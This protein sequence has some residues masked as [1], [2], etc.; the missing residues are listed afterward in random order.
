MND[1]PQVR[2]KDQLRAGVYARL[3]ETYDAAESVPTQ[4]TNATR[5][6]E[7]RG[8]RVAATF[9]DDGYSAFKE[10][11]RDDFVRLIDAI[12]HGEIDVVIVRDVDRLTRNLTDWNRFEKACVG[13]GVLLSAYTGG[14]LDLSTPE[15]AYYGGMETLRAKRESAVRSARVREAKDR[16][17]RKG[18]RSGGGPRWFGYT[19][20]YANPDEPDKRKRIVLRDEI[21]QV[22]AEA[23]R[24]AAERLLRGETTGSIIREW[25]RRGITPSGGQEW[26]VTSLTRTITSPRLAGLRQ[27]QGK[28][29][30]AEWP[31]IFDTDTHERLVKLFGDPS[32]RAH[33]VGRKLHLLSGIAACGKCG[34]PLYPR[35]E[36][37]Y[38]SP[39]YRCVKQPGGGGCGGISVNAELLEEY[40]T[41]AVLDALESPRVQ[42]AVRAGEDS[43]APRRAELLAEI[44]SAQE[45]REEARRDYAEGEIDRGDWLDIKQRTDQRIT[46]ARKE[47][48][49]LTG[50]ATIFGD[51]PAAEMVR[52][53]WDGSWN[54]DRK[55]AA[56]KAVLHRVVISPQYSSSYGK[57]KDRARRRELMLEAV[58]KR[59][60]FD[61]RF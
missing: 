46:K 9:K 36:D 10:I 29:Y 44:Q 45:R 19:R 31:A 61:W 23:L 26:H 5:H 25:T 32:R 42:E 30:A 1:V 22:E 49:R 11:T 50:S 15:G 39:S 3:S 51:I 16:E 40:V 34:H 6:A 41:G 8:W 20:V 55:R 47:Y 21:N 48:D 7:R 37:K 27:W 35:P 54:T 17:A 57:M 14:D 43:S 52:D 28:K 2:T 58:I 33:V 38:R 18:K 53:A 24:D 12:E 13:H 4:L 59:T 56:I 60:E